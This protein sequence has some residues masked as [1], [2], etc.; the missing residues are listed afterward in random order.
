KGVAMASISDSVFES[1]GTDD[2][3]LS[4]DGTGAP[5]FNVRLAG[6]YFERTYFGNTP[7]AMITTSGIISQLQ[8]RD[9]YFH[10]RNSAEFIGTPRILKSDSSSGSKLRGCSMD[11]CNITTYVA[12]STD[13]IVLGNSDDSFLETNVFVTQFATGYPVRKLTVSGETT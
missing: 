7:N 2:T 3:Y 12:T 6:C 10:A 8:I 1:A 13:D 9:S 11:N 5:V 4:L